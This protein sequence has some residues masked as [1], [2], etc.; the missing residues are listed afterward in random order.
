MHYQSFIHSYNLPLEFL[1]WSGGGVKDGLGEGLLFV[2][3]VKLYA[4]LFVSMCFLKR[5]LRN[6]SCSLLTTTGV[7]DYPN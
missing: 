4:H 7:S 6:S 2:N 5:R 3:S 1:T